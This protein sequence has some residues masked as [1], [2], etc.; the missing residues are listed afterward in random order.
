MFYSNDN[1]PLTAEE[2]FDRAFGIH[3]RADRDW[4]QLAEDAY[5]RA[6]AKTGYDKQIWLRAAEHAVRRM[7]EERRLAS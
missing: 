2:Q 5:A 4:R 7:K 3:E 1:A 6:Q